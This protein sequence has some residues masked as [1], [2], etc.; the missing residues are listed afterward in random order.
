MGNERVDIVDIVKSTN[1]GLPTTLASLLSIYVRHMVG[2][3]VQDLSLETVVWNLEV[4]TFQS[5]N[6]TYQRGPSECNSGI[7]GIQ[8]KFESPRATFQTSTIMF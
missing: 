6:I 2:A 5:H 3:L 7:L 4:C 1:C 8:S